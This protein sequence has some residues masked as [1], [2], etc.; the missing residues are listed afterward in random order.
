MLNYMLTPGPWLIALKLSSEA[1]VL[2]LRTLVE[3][4]EASLGEQSFVQ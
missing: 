2:R 1:G 3:L 4:V